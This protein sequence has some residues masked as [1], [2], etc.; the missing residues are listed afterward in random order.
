MIPFLV[1]LLNWIA[2]ASTQQYAGD[3]I[4]NS[5]PTYPGIEIAYFRVPDPSSANNK[6]T[7]INYSVLGSNGQRVTPSS[8]KRAVIMVHGQNRNAGDYAQFVCAL[9]SHAH[10]TPQLG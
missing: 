5:L 6:L 1:L 8:I 9:Y 7:L 2:L 10:V 4:P 3:T